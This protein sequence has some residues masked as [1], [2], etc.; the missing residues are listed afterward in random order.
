MAA[1]IET[2]TFGALAPGQF[3][4]AVIALTSRLPNNW[5][6]LRLAI[7]LRRFVTVR[8]AYPDGA[9]DVVRWGLRLR[10]HPRDNGCEKNLLFTPQMYETTELAELTAEIASA[11]R[12]RASF[13]FVDIGA[14]VGL[15]SFFVAACA[16]RSARILAVEPEKGN[17]ERFF[18]NMRANP[19]LP[20][21]VVSAALAGEAGTLAVEPDRRDR[22]GTR[23]H[24]APQG[25]EVT[26]EAKTL[27]QLLTQEGVESIDAL[28]IDV[29]GMED[30]ILSSFFR[31]GPQRLWPRFILVEDASAVWNTDL[32]SLLAANGY[33]VASRSRQ[34]VM[35]R[36][37]QSLAL[38]SC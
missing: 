12:R 14:N 28:K 9:L 11:K 15:F 17:L 20:I 27:L 13:V 7:L 32:F 8:L 2:A 31:D 24:Q 38:E 1:S 33:S 3:D 25:G 16:G 18:F 6:G 5:L 21:R 36:S 29:E 22:G 30:S 35:L 26:I 23:V 37:R 10:L 4:R 19:G 34:N